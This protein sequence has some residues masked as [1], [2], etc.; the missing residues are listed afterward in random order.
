ML[1]CCGFSALTGQLASLDSITTTW[2]A[3]DNENDRTMDWNGGE[4]PGNFCTNLS[5]PEISL[6]V[7]LSH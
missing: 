2:Q 6:Q 7:D 3:S 5:Q 1:H 4:V